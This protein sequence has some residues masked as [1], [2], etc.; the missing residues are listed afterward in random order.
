[1]LLRL[2]SSGAIT[3]THLA[4]ARYRAVFEGAAVAIIISG[5]N[6]QII[7]ANRSAQELVGYSLEELTTL[8]PPSCFVNPEDLA[9]LVGELTSSGQLSRAET[10]IRSKSG[11]T[12]WVEVNA[13][14]FAEGSESRWLA[15]AIDVT[16]RRAAEAALKQANERLIQLAD[17][18]ADRFVTIFSDITEKKLAASK[19]EEATARLEEAQR[20]AGLGS[21]EWDPVRDT[22]VGS[23]EFHH[24]FDVPKDRLRTSL[25]LV[26]RLHPDD[27]QRFMKDAREALRG[28]R[29]FDAD[30]RVRLESGGWRVLQAKVRTLSDSSGQVTRAV[31]ACLDVTDRRRS[32][33]VAAIRVRLLESATSGTLEELL[34]T[35]ANEIEA[36]TESPAG[37]FHLV[38]TD[39]SSR[40][41]GAWSAGAS[42]ELTHHG[43]EGGARLECLREARPVI[44]EYA[45]GASSSPI[46]RELAV[47]VVREDRVV[48]VL[49]A[50]NAPQPHTPA[51]VELVASVADFAWEIVQRKL[52]EQQRT[53]IEASMAESDRLASLGMLAS[54]VAHEINNPLTY[55]QAN[56][57][58]LANDI[59][60]LVGLLTR[61]RSELEARVGA[62]EL[63]KLLGDELETFG[64]AKLEEAIDRTQEALS[65]TRR[66]KRIVRS[67][68]AFSRVERAEV[69]PVDVNH[70]IEHAINL[71]SN[72]LKYRARVVKDFST[73]PPIRASDAK[74]AQVILNLLINAAHAIEEGH[75]DE[76]EVRVRT[77][78][79]GNEVGIEVSDTGKGIAEELRVRIFE[80][81]FTTKPAGVGSGLGLSICRTIITSFG[82]EL[83]LASSTGRGAR[84]VIRLPASRAPEVPSPPPRASEA[85][86]VRGRILVVDDE[87]GIRKAISRLLSADHEIATAASGKEARALLE[88]DSAFDVI[89]CDLMM[90]DMSGMELHSWLTARS[91]PLAARVVFITGG[92]FTPGAAAYLAKVGNLRVE[93]PFDALVLKGLANE[94]VS[95]AR[96][97]LPR[98]DPR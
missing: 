12:R 2:A 51:E 93:K 72:E 92:A 86:A 73:V 18:R 89:F 74:L 15:V 52:A 37:Y 90:P 17:G 24:L 68:G 63:R 81:F 49:G 1:M 30:F 9:R 54:G 65:G 76:N 33:L 64:P 14:A 44:R 75:T 27:R 40:G 5:P 85:S 98:D 6:G 91:P 66:V 39:H 94:R 80:P 50:A 67:L 95:A 57:E 43:L 62:A 82:G 38:P 88:N 45:P 48:A 11:E 25:D 77:F 56:V 26:E 34:R 83:T 71:A 41:L 96:S 3:S 13:R 20:M 31:G 28:V 58:T 23:E 84:F 79:E 87:L 42:V 53:R 16:Q 32:Q 60:R 36:A 35:T 19:L 29:P 10:Q 61:T 78:T 46:A 69:G 47:P 97:L 55:V 4:E 7:D 21:F 8:D 70:C 22:I 59:P